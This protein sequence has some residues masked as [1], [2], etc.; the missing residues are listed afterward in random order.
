LLRPGNRS[1]VAVLPMQGWPNETGLATEA[2][3]LRL[4]S[5]VINAFSL[6]LLRNSQRIRHAASEL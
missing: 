5:Q 3:C 1:A 2:K 4:I 6:Q